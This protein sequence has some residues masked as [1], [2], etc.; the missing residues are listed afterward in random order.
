MPKRQLRKD[1]LKARKSISPADAKLAAVKAADNFL[2][3]ISVKNAGIIASYLPIHGEISPLPLLDKITALASAKKKKIIYALPTIQSRNSHLLF[4]E[5]KSGD[6]LK[7]SAI[8][9]QLLEVEAQCQPIIPD[10]IIVPLVGFDESC[11]R[12]GYGGGFYD[13]TI[14][15]I[16]KLRKRQVNECGAYPLMVGYAYESQKS[17]SPLPTN[18]YD[19]QLDFV[20]TDV[21]VYAKDRSR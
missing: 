12:M 14:Q 10:I 15:E 11:H 5:W 6:K 2:E 19:M 1:Y 16:R 17:A 9:P 13:R 7:G 8:Y 3:A 20:V 4:H 21:H 18:Q